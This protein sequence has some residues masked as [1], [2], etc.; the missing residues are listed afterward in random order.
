[1]L[2]ETAFGRVHKGRGISTRVGVTRHRTPPESLSIISRPAKSA[3]ESRSK[4]RGRLYLCDPLL[5]RLAQDL[6]DMPPALRPFIQDEHA[7]GRPQ[8]LARRGQVPAADQPHIR[9]GVIGARRGWVMTNRPAPP[10]CFVIS[11]S[12][13]ASSWY[14]EP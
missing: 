12:W 14:D 7:V 4:T 10:G 11:R 1:M 3:R 8:S 9:D 6:E 13:W 2:R 5:Q